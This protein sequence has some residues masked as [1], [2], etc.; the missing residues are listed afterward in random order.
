[1]SSTITPS[2]EP[3]VAAPPQPDALIRWLKGFVLLGV[4]GMAL[5]LITNWLISDP[6]GLF[7]PGTAL[8]AALYAS[9]AIGLF[10]FLLLRTMGVSTRKA[11][12]TLLGW[13]A[14]LFAAWAVGLAAAAAPVLVIV[15][16][17][18]LLSVL[19]G[20]SFALLP[21][22][23][24]GKQPDRAV[25]QAAAWLAVYALCA[26][27]TLAAPGVG[28]ALILLWSAVAA[29]QLLLLAR[30]DHPQ[31]AAAPITAPPAPVSAPPA[32]VTP[33]A[34]SL[35]APARDRLLNRFPAAT[36]VLIQ[37]DAS[38]VQ[39]LVRSTL[40]KDVAAEIR[41]FALRTLLEHTLKSWWRC[42][43]TA[44]LTAQDLDDLRSFVQVAVALALDG[45]SESGLGN[46]P[47][48]A[49]FRSVL[50]ALLDDWVA[51]KAEEHA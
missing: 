36:L 5:T 35:P 8:A 10:G 27:L 37:G 46:P 45:D 23:N 24:G 25:P 44:A 13:C 42:G 11:A 47:N 6:A 9:P 32:P 15:A 4:G 26:G 31:L 39:A 21:A 43:R 30:R 48:A 12:V 3:G 18:L 41:D 50:T 19:G 22:L 40:S 34:P 14:G 2:P 33:L 17:W 49:V 28:R 38:D 7:G 20:A 51:Y 29:T 1:M 16:F